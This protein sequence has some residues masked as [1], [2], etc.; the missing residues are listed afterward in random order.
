MKKYL[1]TCESRA[2]KEKHVFIVSAE[3]AESAREDFHRYSTH[4]ITQLKEI[5][6]NL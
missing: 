3:S 5:K 4:R 1:I 2:T 6:I